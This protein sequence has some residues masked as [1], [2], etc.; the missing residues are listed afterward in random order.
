MGAVMNPG[1]Q[2]ESA[3]RLCEGTSLDPKGDQSRATI[4]RP[5]SAIR[6]IVSCAM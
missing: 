6:K 3:E 1:V 2:R 4:G 5:M